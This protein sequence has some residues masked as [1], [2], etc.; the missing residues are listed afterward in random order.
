MPSLVV[1]LPGQPAT[2]PA[3]DSRAP[4]TGTAPRGTLKIERWPQPE[5][6][7]LPTNCYY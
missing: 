5:I 7:P 3:D 6:E 4:A 2:L 1:R